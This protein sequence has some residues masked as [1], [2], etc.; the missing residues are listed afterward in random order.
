MRFPEMRHPGCGIRPCKKKHVLR[1]YDSSAFTPF[2]FNDPYFSAVQV[3]LVPFQM[4]PFVWPQAAG[5][6][7]PKVCTEQMR[8]EWVAWILV[9]V[10]FMEQRCQLII[11][12]Q[13]RNEYS[14]SGSKPVWEDICRFPYGFL[15]FPQRPDKSCLPVDGLR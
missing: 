10:D 15:I 1:H 5:I 3:N 8:T 13:I 11:P 7:H 12:K 6:S 9:T 14:A 4:P 2:C